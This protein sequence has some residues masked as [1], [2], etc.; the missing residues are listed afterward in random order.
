MGTNQA[1]VRNADVT[2][3]VRTNVFGQSPGSRFAVVGLGHGLHANVHFTSYLELRTQVYTAQTGMLGTDALIGGLDIDEDDDRSTAFLVVEN[4][5]PHPVAVAC[6]RVIGRLD[7]D[8]RPLPADALYALGLDGEGVEV[9][10]Y[11]ARL[12]DPQAQS[13]VLVEMLRST[14]AHIR[15]L[16]MDD[17][18]YAVVERPLERVL[19]IMGVG[20]TRVA[21]PAW[22]DEYQGVNLAIRLDPIASAHNLGGLREIDELD[23]S[24]GSVRFWGEVQL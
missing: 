23:V 11:I 18:V 3:Q 6:V 20:V 21:E 8:R 24:E 15:Q 4:R 22:I 1:R 5:H 13:R 14:I 17:H 2:P 12:D 7:S 16:G 9:S 19:R 10:R